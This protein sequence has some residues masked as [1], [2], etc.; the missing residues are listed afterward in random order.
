M[1]Q[2]RFERP[3]RPWIERFSKG[4]QVPSRFSGNCTSTL[5]PDALERE[6]PVCTNYVNR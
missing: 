5:R 1:S 3:S 2:L 6:V 4:T